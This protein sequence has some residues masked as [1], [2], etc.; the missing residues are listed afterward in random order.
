MY[1]LLSVL[2][3]LVASPFSPISS[4]KSPLPLSYL[5]FFCFP[6]LYSCLI[7]LNLTAIYPLYRN[8]SP[9]LLLLTC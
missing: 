6:P 2:Y 3:L 1:I 5:F 9:L 4:I 8:H 7:P